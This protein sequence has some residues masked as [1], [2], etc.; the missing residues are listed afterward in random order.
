MFSELMTDRITVKTSE[1]KTFTNVAASVQG[2][3]VITERTDIPLRPGDQISRK[4]PAGVEERFTIE[5]PGFRRG[6]GDLPDTYQ[7]RVRVDDRTGIVTQMAK[8][9]KTVFISYRRTAVSWAQSIFQNLT[10]HGY[11]VFL[12]FRASP[13]VPSR[14]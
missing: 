11:D 9:E 6:V 2:N 4:T 1:G 8:L 13:V 14:K 3:K 12:I 10:Q 5:D 7:M